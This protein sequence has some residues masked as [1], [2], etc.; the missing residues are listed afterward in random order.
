M[1]GRDAAAAVAAATAVLIALGIRILKGDL[2]G[3]SAVAFSTFWIGDNLGDPG[4]VDR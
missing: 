2:P 1:T 3:G 4:D